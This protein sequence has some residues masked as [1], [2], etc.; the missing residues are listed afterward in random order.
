MKRIAQILLVLAMFCPFLAMAQGSNVDKA[1]RDRW[2]KEI[3]DKKHDFF[4]K[5]LDLSREQQEPF[6]KA[7]DAMEDEL[8]RIADQVRRLERRVAHQSNPADDDYEEAID[9]LFEQKG[10]EYLVE[11]QAREQFSRILSKKQL[12]KLKAAE[13]KF[14][15]ALMNHRGPGGEGRKHEDR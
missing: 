5:E 12:F 11:K 13:R 2:F 1:T 7:Y 4:T 8:F 14:T 10:K 15:R 3:R 9:A 6:F